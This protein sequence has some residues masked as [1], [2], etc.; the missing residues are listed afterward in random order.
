MP[1]SETRTEIIRLA[2]SLMAET[3]RLRPTQ[4]SP[5]YLAFT[6]TFLPFSAARKGGTDEVKNLAEEGRE[7]AWPKGR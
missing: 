3:I 7:T 4:T 6:N 1:G 5:L 2:K